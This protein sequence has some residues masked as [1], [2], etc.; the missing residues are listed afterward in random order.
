[1]KLKDTFM[2]GPICVK[3]LTYI[4][5]FE[6]ISFALQTIFPFITLKQTIFFSQLHLANNFLKEKG[7]PLIKKWSVPNSKTILMTFYA[8]EECTV[9][10][11]PING[12]Q[13]YSSECGVKGFKGYTLHL[14]QARKDLGGGGG[15]R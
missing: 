9:A 4:K 8:H 10:R 13:S 7:N 11:L 12:Q 1:M 15:G 3:I 5:V 2:S 6:K 14:R